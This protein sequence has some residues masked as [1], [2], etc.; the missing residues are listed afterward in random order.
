MLH[1]QI[2][3]ASESD[4][5]A[6]MKAVIAELT[7]RY[8]PDCAHSLDNAL[9]NVEAALDDLDAEITIHLNDRRVNSRLD[10]RTGL[11]ARGL[12]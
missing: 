5:I 2:K 4:L 11:F 3:Q 10:R 9:S 7:A 12:A 6:S 8:T 1:T